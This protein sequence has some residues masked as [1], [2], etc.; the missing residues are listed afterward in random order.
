MIAASYS[1][2]RELARRRLPRMLFDY[3]DGGANSEATLRRNT[4]AMEKVA[5][6]QRVMRDVSNL[7]LSTELFGETLSM[8]VVLGPVG[9]AGLYARRGE[10]QAARA[11]E[12][13]GIT[14]C[15]SSM[16]ICG[17]EEVRKAL[18]RPAWF[19]LYM[20]KDRAYMREV[21]ARARAVEAPVLVFTVDLPV[22]GT[23][24]RDVRSG[25]SGKLP[26]AARLRRA[27]DGASHPEWLWDVMLHGRPHTFGNLVAALPDARG[28]S[29]FW[30]WVKENFDP[31]VTWADLAWVREQWPGPIVVKGVLDVEDARAAVS[32][33]ADGIVV[34][35]HG[36]RQLDG[37]LAG[38]E[39]LPGIAEAVG[40]RTTVLVDGGVRSGLDVLRALALGA[41]GCV[42]GRAWAF[43]LAARGG[44]GVAHMLE[45]IRGELATAMAVTGC[46]DVR[47]AGRDL[48]A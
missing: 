9:M 18:Q 32:A 31:S 42:L 47:A 3:V 29:E 16:S 30:V 48:L 35:N 44:A 8:P 2:Y 15:L 20:I 22:P 13:A 46:T 38:I 34:S 7:S 6:R 28:A 27:V 21:L 40:D 45:M 36:G 14:S 39:A 1:D 41:K 17:M 24:Y 11:A 43:P 25:L 5:L 26:P 23:R 37:T 33:G 10:V 4:E 19:Q 12:G